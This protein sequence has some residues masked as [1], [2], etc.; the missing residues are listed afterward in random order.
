M[1]MSVRSI[2]IPIAT[3]NDLV[4]EEEIELLGFNLRA[5]SPIFPSIRRFCFC[6]QSVT[7]V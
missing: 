2:A 3:G 4:I 6:I 1:G 7:A 5:Q